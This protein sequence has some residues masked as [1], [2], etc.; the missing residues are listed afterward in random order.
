MKYASFILLG[1]FILFR[2]SAYGWSNQG[3]KIIVQ[4]AK[5]QLDKETIGLIDVYLNGQSWEDAACWMNNVATNP[6]YKNLQA[7]HF[8]YFNKDKTYVKTK[9]ENAINKLEYCLRM[10]QYRQHQTAETMNEIIKTIFHIVGDLHQPL[11]CGYLDDK[12]G[13]TVNVKFLE[14]DSNLHKVW[15]VDILEESKIDIWACTNYLMGMKLTPTKKADIEKADML[16][17]MNESRML[18]PEIYKTNQG[19]IDKAYVEKNTEVI[20]SQLIKA[21]LRLAALLKEAF[22]T[23]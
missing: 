19:K 1:C 9:E 20:K 21:G 14:K 4:I 5:S 11:D 2:T 18:L 10:F 17:W 22:K 15:N 23:K 7:C 12:G 8:I 6:K 3:H 13:S 16:A